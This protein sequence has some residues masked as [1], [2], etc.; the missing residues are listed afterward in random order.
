MKTRERRNFPI[1]SKLGGSFDAYRDPCQMWL[2]NAFRDFHSQLKT[3]DKYW[4][5]KRRKYL[6]TG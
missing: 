2:E 1:Y 4:C 5:F 3:Q 6:G